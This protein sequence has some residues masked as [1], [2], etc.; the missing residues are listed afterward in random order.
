M[1]AFI[2]SFN[3]STVSEESI[4]DFLDSKPEVLNWMSV[5]PNTIFLASNASV[6]KLTKVFS[7]K[8]PNAFF[9]VYEYDTRKA[10]GALTDEA[11][12]FLNNPESA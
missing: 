6:E 2:F 4:F 12:D 1:K 3:D 9:L 10:N 11:W 8:F 7:R 5:L